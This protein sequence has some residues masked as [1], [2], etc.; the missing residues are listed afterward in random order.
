MMSNTSRSCRNKCWVKPVNYCPNWI[1]DIFAGACARE[2]IQS[3]LPLESVS[4]KFQDVIGKTYDPVEAGIVLKASENIVL[5]LHEADAGDMS[6][7]IIDH[8]C[9]FRLNFEMNKTPRKISGIFGS[10]L[11]GERERAYN[12]DETRKRFKAFLFALRN[13]GMKPI[14]EEW[15]LEKDDTIPNLSEA[16]SNKMGMLDLI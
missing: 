4:R 7:R 16:V 1:F 11:K 8:F 13:G 14:P 3:P 12:A 6:V 2:F 10:A 15:N 9:Y 5:T